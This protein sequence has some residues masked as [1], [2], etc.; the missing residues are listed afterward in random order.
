MAWQVVLTH[1]INGEVGVEVSKNYFKGK[2]HYSMRIG[3][4]KDAK[5]SLFL[6][7]DEVTEGD[8]VSALFSAKDFILEDRAEEARKEVKRLE[9]LAGK[10][11][12]KNPQ[13]NSG[14]S[15]F[16]KKKQVA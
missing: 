12:S 9:E 6:N 10:G 1:N 2:A 8:I 15:R 7:P 5:V 3:R 14:L 4:M 11:R 13:A 16:S